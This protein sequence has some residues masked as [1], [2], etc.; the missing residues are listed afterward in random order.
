MKINKTINSQYNINDVVEF[1]PNKSPLQHYIG[2]ITR[3][4]YRKNEFHYRIQ[5]LGY[6]ADIVPWRYTW[7]KKLEVY[8]R[9]L[10]C[11]IGTSRYVTEYNILSIHKG[12]YERE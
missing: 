8:D 11:K 1:L 3:V 9:A 12:R 10:A 6:L 4:L 5:I 2:K 7:N